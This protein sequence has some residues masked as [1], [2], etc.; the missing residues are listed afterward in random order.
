MFIL[1]IYVYTRY[2]QNSKI[3]PPPFLRSANDILMLPAAQLIHFCVISL[4]RNQFLLIVSR[5]LCWK[6]QWC[7]SIF[8]RLLQ[9]GFSNNKK[10]WIHNELKWQYHSYIFTSVGWHYNCTEIQLFKI[11]VSTDMGIPS[12]VFYT[13]LNPAY[14][15]FF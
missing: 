2:T 9:I 14:M 4:K 13:A 12:I 8:Q 3:S 6:G 15:E 1:I 10:N 11:I 7:N 5:L